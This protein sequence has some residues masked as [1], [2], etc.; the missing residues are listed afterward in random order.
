MSATA[1]AHFNELTPAEAE[2]LA[3][4]IEECSEVVHAAAKVLR[5]GYDSFDPTDESKGDNRRMLGLE[6][7]D[8]DAIIGLMQTAGDF[9]A[10]LISQGARKKLLSLQR[11]AHHQ[12]AES[13]KVPP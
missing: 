4:L 6:L 3:M 9:R 2:R 11:Y 12:P 7:G 13:L 10:G 5:H 1:P 8:L